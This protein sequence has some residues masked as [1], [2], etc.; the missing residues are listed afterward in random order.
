MALSMTDLHWA[1]G[2]LEG[3]GSFTAVRAGKRPDGRPRESF[4]LMVHAGQVERGPLE[5][6]Q[7]LFGGSLY[8][9]NMHTGNP[10][11]R[12]QI[13]GRKAVALMMT[14]WALMST[15]RR[16]QIEA[17]IEKWKSNAQPLSSYRLGR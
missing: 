15:R 6:L 8:K 5:K 1:A 9:H 12:W 3:E 13:C 14:M 10:C 17:S 16:G 11:V 4:N 2:F 7:R